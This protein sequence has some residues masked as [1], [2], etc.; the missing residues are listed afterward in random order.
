MV[1][2]IS[3]RL[4]V[5]L[6]DKWIGTNCQ[7]YR[8]IVNEWAGKV[9][10]M[11]VENAQTPGSETKQFYSSHQQQELE[12]AFSSSCFSL[13][14]IEWLKAGQVRPAHAEDWA[15]GRNS[16]LVGPSCPWW[17]EMTLYICSRSDIVSLFLDIYYIKFLRKNRDQRLDMLVKFWPVPLA[18]DQVL[19]ITPG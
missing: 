1:Q 16:V 13:A 14:L 10:R 2:G 9:S 18:Y 19:C 15:A 6:K 4:W 8:Q 11:L 12:L 3:W 7:R 17:V 5:K